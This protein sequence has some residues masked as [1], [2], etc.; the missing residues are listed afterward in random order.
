MRE[1]AT[2]IV[3]LA[4]AVILSTYV[5][6]RRERGGELDFILFVGVVLVGAGLI[7]WMTDRR[8]G[9]DQ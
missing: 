7:G 4:G 6:V 5:V 3:I 1:L 8:K 2:S 9:R